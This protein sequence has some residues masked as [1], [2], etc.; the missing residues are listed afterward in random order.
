MLF[1]FNKYKYK[2]N[3]FYHKSFEKSIRHNSIKEE[4]VTYLGLNRENFFKMTQR[5]TSFDSPSR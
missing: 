5:C 3:Q 4:G 1:K 2:N